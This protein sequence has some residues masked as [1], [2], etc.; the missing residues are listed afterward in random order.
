MDSDGRGW[1]DAA[2][3]A[4]LAGPPLLPVYA[5]AAL[6]H[7]HRGALLA[8]G[9][10][11]CEAELLA[12]AGALP[13][14]LRGEP[15]ATSDGSARGVEDVLA[16]ALGVMRLCP[17][18]LLLAA[19]APR[20]VRVLREDWPRLADDAA[21]AATGGAAAAAAAAAA[22]TPRRFA[23]L[24]AD[25]VALLPD[26]RPLL[27]K[28]GAWRRLPPC[29][30]ALRALIGW[31][32]D[33]WEDWPSALTS[34]SALLAVAAIVV[35]TTA[36]TQYDGAFEGDDAGRRAIHQLLA[37]AKAAWAA[38]FGA[39]AEHAGYEEGAYF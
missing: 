4:F 2:D 20:V 31:P 10:E 26:A 3:V 13:A 37:L 7:L 14:A 9:D 12:A 24:D 27:A 17:P 8:L 25:Y 22:A 15:D 32:R 28:R 5:A 30:L 1:L 6:L 19:T 35:T 34:I 16:L 18:G 39:A 23:L 29:P 11:P 38:A 36:E 33:A 21:A